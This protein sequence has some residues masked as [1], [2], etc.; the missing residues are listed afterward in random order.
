[1]KNSENGGSQTDFT[2]LRVNTFLQRG[3][4]LRVTKKKQ[5]RFDGVELEMAGYAFCFGS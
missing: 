2:L 1:M 4:S 5:S 3:V